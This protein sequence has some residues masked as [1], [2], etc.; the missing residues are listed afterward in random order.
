LTRPD[1]GTALNP[2]PK[3]LEAK[4]S[5][6][7]LAGSGSLTAPDLRQAKRVKLPYLPRVGR[8]RLSC[9]PS[10]AASADNSGSHHF[11]RLAR[12]LVN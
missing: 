2:E 7:V 6:G 4:P 12:Q 8:K 5:E 1:F 9:K 10:E 11:P 3:Q